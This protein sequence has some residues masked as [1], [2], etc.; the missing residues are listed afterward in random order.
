M[1]WF[2]F[3]REMIWHNAGFGSIRKIR[4]HLENYEP[5]FNPAVFP[6]PLSKEDAAEL[7]HEEAQLDDDAARQ[8]RQPAQSAQSS[9]ISFPS[10]ANYRDLYLA[11]HLTPNDVVR[12]ILPL[13]RGDTAPPGRHSKAWTEMRIDL[14]LEAA[15]AS[16]LRYQS[17]TSL[18][19]L[20]GVPTAIKD[21]YDKDGYE[22]T[23]GSGKN[24]AEAYEGVSNTSWCV[25]K[26]E[27]SGAINL[28]KLHMH[29][30][31]LGMSSTHSNTAK[32]YP[33]IY[34]YNWKQSNPRHPSQPVQP[35][36]LHWRK[37]IRSSIC[38]QLG[39]D[40]HCARE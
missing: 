30:F 38:R 33:N 18:G 10:V 7:E 6:L 5:L 29:E 22:T 13:V 28:G 39:L 15:E 23:L 37:F 2:R 19:P 35:A 25:R 3:I 40:P 26:L 20:D 31:G 9:G 8:Q 17:K 16:T 4:S 36:L 32:K 34:R 14:I 27:E 24:Y 12:A 1:E 21:D 11:G